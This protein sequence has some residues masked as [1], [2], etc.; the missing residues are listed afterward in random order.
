[1]ADEPGDAVLAM[2]LRLFEEL[3]SADVDVAMVEVLDAAAALRHLDLADRPLLRTA[4]RS[5][6]VK[7]LE[8][9]AVFE[10]LFD[11]CFPLTRAATGSGPAPG[12]DE[13][14]RPPAPGGLATPGPA[15]SA[16]ALGRATAGEAEDARTDLIEALL[17]ALR[18]GDANALESLAAQAVDAYSGLG[19][20]TGSE[21]YFLYRVLRALDLATLL[22]AAMRQERIEGATDGLALRLRRDELARRIEEFRRLLADEVRRQHAPFPTVSP[23]QV[24]RLD[25]LDVLEVS[26]TELAALRQAVR[27]LARKLAARVAQ[28][29]RHHR[30]G[31]LDVRRTTRRSLAFGGVPMDPAFR[32]RR[33]SKPD[34]VVLCD[35]SGSVAEFAGFTLGLVH[36]LHAEMARLRTFVF[37]D[38]VAEVTDLLERAGGVPDAF[39]LV[40]RAGVVSGDGHSDYGRVFERFWHRDA[41]ATVGPSTTVIIT[42][43]AR[44]NY[45][46]AGLDFF[47]QLCSTAKRVYW[48]N[49]ERRHEWDRDD[50]VISA[51]GATCTSVF[52]V[53]TLRQLADAVAE[54][55]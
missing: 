3:R 7:R 15:G 42:G 24:R 19:S 28:R 12:T 23:S 32:R 26:R 16:D 39:H 6:L 22:S 55:I 25:D 1:V 31:R 34:V 27:P 8:D 47:R 54:I 4:L 11:R 2:V 21:R 37:V 9:E 51:Y 5:T 13:S 45:R 20:V 36:A 52:E 43:D 40:G 48:L 44:T 38:G 18:A 41:P 30:G 10:V 50:S 17:A 53:R 46:T 35:V 29:R 33:V 14:S 49:P